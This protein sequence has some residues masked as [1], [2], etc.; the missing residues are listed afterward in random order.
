MP[1]NKRKPTTV[2]LF[3]GAGGESLGK[4]KALRD[5]GVDVSSIVSLAVNHWNLAVSCHGSN[6]P[7]IKVAQEDITQVTAASFGLKKIHCL[8]ASPSCTH[9]SRARGGKPVNEQMRSH[10]D[11]VIDRWLRVADVDVLVV[12][13]V[14][15]LVDWGPVH[16]THSEGCPGREVG[17]LHCPVRGCHY[18]QP[19]P[20]R[21]GQFFR[22]FLGKLT[23]LGYRYDW[24][25][26]TAADHGDP[27]T[28][29]RFFLIAN[30]DGRPIVWPEATHRDP[31]SQ[32]GLFDTGQKPWKTAAS[33]IDWSIPTPSIFDRKKPLAEATLRRI[34]KGV[35]RYVLQ[36]KPYIVDLAAHDKAQTEQRLAAHTMVQTG[37][38]EREG[39]AP[40]CLDLQRPLGTIVA[41]GTKHAL[42]AAFL[43]KY[44]PEWAEI[45]PEPK[46]GKPKPG[47]REVKVAASLITIDQQSSGP[48]ACRPAG[49]PLSTTTTK[50]RHALVAAFLTHYYSTGGQHQGPASPLH[51]ITTK[52]RHGLVTVS[53]D[54]ETYVVTD[55]GFRMLDPV[56][57]GRAM[58]FPDDFRWIGPNGEPVSKRDRVVM[59]GNACPVNTVAAIMRTIIL[60]RPEVYGLGPTVRAS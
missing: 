24:R 40:R 36:S 21:K 20:E 48:G 57:L 18:Q 52:A 53:L 34:A 58:S 42:V 38:G 10:A 3:C 59:I 1:L 32:I 13:N 15:E 46:I 7:W 43:D 17:A 19:I 44:C 29:K 4:A 41:G 37:Y 2:S 25:I 16:Q 39:Q 35:F 55:I 6:F 45:Q 31:R 56:E 9:H 49:L 22:R 54:G 12:E 14:P 23:D 47:P 11:E 8:W 33:C 26:L 50:A 30:K 60:Q 27:T 5:L 51:T 28:R